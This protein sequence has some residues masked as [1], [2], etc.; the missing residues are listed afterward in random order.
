MNFQKFPKMGSSAI[1]NIDMNDVSD[2][3][4][5]KLLLL[6]KIWITQKSK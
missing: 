5:L 4:S 2:V 3:R 6:P 1:E